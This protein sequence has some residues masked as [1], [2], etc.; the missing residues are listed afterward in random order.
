MYAEDELILL[1]ILHIMA[2]FIV[3]CLKKMLKILIKLC[4]FD[5]Q[6]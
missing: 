2:L 6:P 3:N 5:L 1:Y 4:G